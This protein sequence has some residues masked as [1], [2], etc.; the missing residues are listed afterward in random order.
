MPRLQKSPLRAT[1]EERAQIGA[2]FYADEVAALG[3]HPGLSALRGST[4][5]ILGSTG[6]LGTAL[7]QS[8][9]AM[10][11]QDDSG[12]TR[13]IGVARRA[14]GEVAGTSFV[15]GST[16][17]PETYERLPAPDYVVYV[18]G[19]TSDAASRPWETVD[20]TLNGLRLCLQ[21]AS[22]ARGIVFVSS[23]RVYGAYVDGLDVNEDT[24]ARVE[25]MVAGN[26]YDASKRLAESLVRVAYERDG[27]PTTTVRL[28]NIYGPYLSRPSGHFLGEIVKELS[29][30][31]R[32]ALRGHPDSTRN[33]CFATD[34]AQ[35]LLLTL[36]RGEPGTAYNVGAREHL[37]N[38]D[39]VGKVAALLEIEDGV[40]VPPSALAQ[41]RTRY[42]LSIGRA[43]ADLGYEPR[44]TTEVCLPYAVAETLRGLRTEG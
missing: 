17:R 15:A 1:L 8:V 27:L 22:H 25:P 34:A 20:V 10:A 44:G 28:A 12:R 32:I 43:A 14:R 9:G 33:Y 37:T 38:A 11:G 36:V 35:G 4:T 3:R 19:N 13:V 21:Y 23:V 24:A 16:T 18:A 41:Q 6:M 2:R 7:M 5:V 29:E 30:R 31:G 26:V 42:T 40:H 39:L